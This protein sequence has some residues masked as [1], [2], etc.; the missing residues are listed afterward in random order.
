[1][2]ASPRFSERVALALLRISLISRPDFAI[3]LFNKTPLVGWTILGRTTLGR[4]TLGRT[5]LGRTTLCGREL[6]ALCGT[7]HGHHAI[8]SP[9]RYARETENVFAV[10][11]ERDM[12][13]IPIEQ[14][15]AEIFLELAQ[16]NAQRG[17]SDAAA[18][19]SAGE[20]QAIRQCDQVSKRA[21]RHA[22]P[23]DPA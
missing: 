4:T 8:S 9:H 5:T 18:L 7:T 2:L 23:V 22:T 20:V 11:S 10:S 15:D 17:L 1:M 14:D 6:A 13:S 12:G 16:L 21:Y 19:G 3:D